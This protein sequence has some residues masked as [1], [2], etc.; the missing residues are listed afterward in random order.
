MST[1]DTVFPASQAI[2]AM[3]RQ[4]ALAERIAICEWL[5]EQPV[6]DVLT[7]AEQIGAGVHL[8]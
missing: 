1:D 2:R 8:G 6:E 7:L 3:C 5:K 4:A